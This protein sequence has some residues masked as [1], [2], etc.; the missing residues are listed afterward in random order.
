MRF[1]SYNLLIMLLLG[2]PLSRSVAAV[3][4]GVVTGVHAQV[5]FL[6]LTDCNTLA[7]FVCFRYLP[8]CTPSGYHALLP[9]KPFLV[10]GLMHTTSKFPVS[11]SAGSV[12]SFFSEIIPVVSTSTSLYIF[13]YS[14]VQQDYSLMCHP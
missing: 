8:G 1:R 3:H 13:S 11:C 4:V 2:L 14:L 9:P 5:G 10:W 7:G 6:S 12:L